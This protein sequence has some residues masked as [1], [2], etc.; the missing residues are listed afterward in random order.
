M[1]NAQSLFKN[2]YLAVV[3]GYFCFT[4]EA[5]QAMMDKGES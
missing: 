5:I 3:V 4:E 2:V 1:H